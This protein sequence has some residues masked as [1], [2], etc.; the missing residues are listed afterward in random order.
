MSEDNIGGHRARLREK[1]RMG[2]P[3]GFLDYEILEL[4]LTYAVPRKDV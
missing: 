2:G 1:Y 4:L 3:D